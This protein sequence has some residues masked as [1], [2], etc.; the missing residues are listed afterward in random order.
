MTYHSGRIDIVFTALEPLHHGAGTS[1]NTQVFRTVETHNPLTGEFYMD[2]IIS[3]NSVKHMIRDGAVRFALDAMGVEDG[4]F[5]KSVVDLL[6]SGGHLGAGAQSV[7]LQA[8][9]DVAR[10]FPALSLCGYS[11]GNVMT[12]SKLSVDIVH[13]VCMENAWRMMPD[14]CRTAPQADKSLWEFRGEEFG[15]R[16]EASR[17]P[18]VM[19]MLS[20]G[21]K[22]LLVAEVT[23][24]KKS[25]DDEGKAQKKSKASS[26]MIYEFQTIAAGSLWWGGMDFHDLTDMERAA[27]LSGLGYSCRGMQ[28]GRYR[29]ALGAKSSI[30]FGAVAA[31]FDG[32]VR[33]LASPGYESSD[34]LVP[35]VGKDDLDAYREHLRD[36]RPDIMALLTR[37]AT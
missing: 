30:G 21:D 23:S 10:L 35:A 29:F 6:M 18:R 32:S 2:P 26:Q 9:R 31:Q 4:A 20:A 11:A 16:H 3:G 13:L 1:G 36:S 7:D 17:D 37:I 22:A 14:S 24:K 33:Q 28:D 34:A 27:L 5:S 19:R 25:K 8:A 12:K 15:T